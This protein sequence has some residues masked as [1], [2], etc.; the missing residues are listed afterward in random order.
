MIK[1]LRLLIPIAIVSAAVALAL[2]ARPRAYQ[3]FMPEPSGADATP[4]TLP[5]TSSGTIRGNVRWDGP[6]PKVPLIEGGMAKLGEGPTWQA[7]PNPAAPKID[8]DTSGIA[9]AVVFIKHVGAERK[10]WPY[11][12]VTIKM[13]VG[14]IAIAQGG[15]EGKIGFVPVGSEVQIVS[16]GPGYQMLRARG[17]A[18]FTQPLPKPDE[19]VGR[20]FPHAGHVALT[21][22]VGY[23]WSEADLFVCEHPYYAI[24]DQQG[25]FELSQVPP[26]EYEIVAWL[27]NW[28]IWSR[29]RDPETGKLMRLNYDTPYTTTKRITVIEVQTTNV[30]L[31]LP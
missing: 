6:P 22:G 9:Y 20:K 21:S 13:P 7:V 29:D 24:T 16:N 30:K 19:P 10:P 26:G 25:R 23:V 27:K 4:K 15:D 5:L 2:Y 28:N 3:V 18:F 31:T 12:P 11:S 8:S 14:K 17:A 1:A